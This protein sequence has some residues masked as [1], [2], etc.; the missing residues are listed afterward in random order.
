M[1]VLE[2]KII[3]YTKRRSFKSP[4]I[5]ETQFEIDQPDFNRNVVALIVSNAAHYAEYETL[6]TQNQIQ[7]RK[8]LER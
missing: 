3:K 1:S 7:K 4:G 5:N 8:Q 2:T 6:F